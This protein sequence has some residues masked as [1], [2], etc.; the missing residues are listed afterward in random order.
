MTHKDFPSGHYILPDTNIFLTQVHTTSIDLLST[1][2]TRVHVKDGLIRVASI[3]TTGYHPSNCHG[4][5]PASVTPSVQS[6][7]GAHQVR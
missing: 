6:A 4:G 2:L 1:V 3:L 5:S 7:Q